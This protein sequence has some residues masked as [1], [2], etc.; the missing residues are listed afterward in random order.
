MKKVKEI[1]NTLLK[2]KEYCFEM[3]AVDK[4]PLRE[5]VRAQIIKLTKAKEN[6]LVL[7][8]IE[9]LFGGKEVKVYAYI[10]E[11]EK[12]LKEVTPSHILKRNFKAVETQKSEE[13]GSENQ[14]GSQ[15]EEVKK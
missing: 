14:K 1:E 9:S 8:K 10:Y 13:E 12:T 5:E 2:R 7:D 4:T 6:L 3:Q 11:D 15:N